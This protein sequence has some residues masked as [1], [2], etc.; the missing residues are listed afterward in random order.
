LPG[1][2]CA[3]SKINPDARGQTNILRAD[4]V[5]LKQLPARRT[6]CPGDA[7]LKHGMTSEGLIAC[8]EM[9]D[10]PA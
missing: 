9:C 1:P 10:G 8:P 4:N 3:E 6:L 5:N 7:A 2:D